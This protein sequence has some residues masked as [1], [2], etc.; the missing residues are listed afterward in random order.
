M[1]VPAALARAG[2]PCYLPPMPSFPLPSAAAPA[3]LPRDIRL[4][5]VSPS[6]EPPEGGRG[7]LHEVKHDGH[8]LLAI[9]DGE[10][11][12][13]LSR[14]GHDRTALFAEPFR[15]LALAGLPSLVLDGEIAVPDERGVTHIDTLSEAIR[16]GRPERLAFFAFDLLHLDGHDLR[17]CAIEDRKALLRDVVGATRCP[18]IVHVGHVRR[19]GP[20]AV[21]GAA[22][23]RG[24]RASSRS[25]AAAST[26]A[27][28]AATG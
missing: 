27:A 8:R 5:I 1:E 20:G 12:R 10:S 3:G 28:R 23:A 19:H 21:R 22:A 25:G 16:A 13:L 17:R 11:I 15:P 6:A 7:W 4:Q 18:R 14:N 9:F 24:P 26:G 2:R